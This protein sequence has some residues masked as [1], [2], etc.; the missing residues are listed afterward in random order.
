MQTDDTLAIEL[1]RECESRLVQF[2]RMNRLSV[3]EAV[4]F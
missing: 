3:E 4:V 1:P 2:A